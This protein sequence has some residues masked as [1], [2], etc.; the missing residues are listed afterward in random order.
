M[1]Q[2][3]CS[4]L[5]RD[6]FRHVFGDENESQGDDERRRADLSPSPANREKWHDRLAD[7][8][9]RATRPRHSWTLRNCAPNLGRRAPRASA[10]LTTPSALTIEP[11]AVVVQSH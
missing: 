6:F 11:D 4:P 5:D 7:T 10:A 8:R 1:P 3:S 9:R 2:T